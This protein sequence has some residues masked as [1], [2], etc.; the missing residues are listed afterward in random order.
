MRSKLL[1]TITITLFFLLLTLICHFP[2]ISKWQLLARYD[3]PLHYSFLVGAYRSVVEFHQLPFWNPYAGGGHPNLYFAETFISSP[4]FFLAYF[5]PLL[6]LKLSVILAYTAGLIGAAFLAALFFERR[7]SCLLFAICY[8]F[9]GFHLSKLVTGMMWSLSAMFIPW[10]IWSFL[11]MFRLN[12]FRYA[13]VTALMTTFMLMNG[14]VYYLVYLGLFFLLLAIRNLRFF[15]SRQSMILCAKFSLLAASLASFK[16]LPLLAITSDYSRN[17]NPSLGGISLKGILYGLTSE[18]VALSFDSIFPAQTTLDLINGWS[19]GLDENSIYVSPIGLS[20]IALGLLLS[21]RK[22]PAGLIKKLKFDYKFL[23]MVSVFAIYLSWGEALAPL[24]FSNLT[25][26]LPVFSQMR[27]PQRAMILLVIVFPFYASIAYDYILDKINVRSHALSQLTGIF[28]VTS[29]LFFLFNF[30]HLLTKDAFYLSAPPLKPTES[31]YHT[32]GG[33]TLLDLSSLGLSNDRLS[34]TFGFGTATFSKEQA[35]Y[36]GE[37]FLLNSREAIQPAYWSPNKFAIRFTSI[38]RKD[39]LVVNQFYEKSWKAYD[40]DDALLP[41][42][43]ID[44]IPGLDPA[45]G[46]M[47][48]E[49]SPNTSFVKVIYEP[50]LAL[51]GLIITIIGIVFSVL[52]FCKRTKPSLD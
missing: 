22:L 4:F 12:S 45:N 21:P 27:V 43:K 13:V 49:L 28:I 8:V 16:L 32:T 31:F 24:A 41:V 44:K 17:I 7:S 30:N 26:R 1:N 14:G 39:T 23:L 42:K 46:L 52:T 2:W 25:S 5:Q 19:Y 3:M 50:Q 40:Q 47:G 6:G 20:L 37:Y 38:H 10:A 18:K 33:S 29:Q 48:I 51:T 34:P 11:Q 9:C 35:N 15:L 36:P